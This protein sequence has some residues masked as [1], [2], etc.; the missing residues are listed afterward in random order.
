MGNVRSTARGNDVVVVDDDKTEEEEEDKEEGDV[1]VPTANG[2]ARVQRTPS[3]SPAVVPRRLS[4]RPGCT[5]TLKNIGCKIVCKTSTRE[6]RETR[7]VFPFDEP[8]EEIGAF[9]PSART[10]EGEEQQQQHQNQNT[11]YFQKTILANVTGVISPGIWA[12][13]GPSGAGKSTLL[14]IITRRKTEGILSGSILLDGKPSTTLAIKKYVSYVAQQD[15]FYGGSTVF[16]TILFIAMIK[17]PGVEKLSKEFVYEQVEQVIQAMN[18]EKCRNTYLGNALVRGVSGGEKKR[19]SI[20]AA[21]LSQP[22][23]MFLDEPTSGLDSQ[24]AREVMMLLADLQRR[25]QRTIVTTIHQ[26]STDIFKI[27]DGLILLNRECVYFGPAGRNPIKFFER[28]EGIPKRVSG[29]SVSEYLL[30]VLSFNDSVD[31]VQHYERSELAA[32]NRE[33]VDKTT[34]YEINVN[35]GNDQ[36]DKQFERTLFGELLFLIRYKFF[37]HWLH[38]LYWFSRVIIYALLA[39]TLSVFFYGQDRTMSGIINTN[40]ILFIMIILPMFMAQ[41][42]VDILKTE[43][44][45]YT[46]EIFHYSY[47]RSLS[48]VTAKIFVEIPAS[49]INAILYT[50]IIFYSIG[51]Q[52][53]FWFVVFA[54]FVNMIVCMLIGY[55]IA[56]IVPGEIGPGVVLPVFSTLNMLVSGFFVRFKTI[57]EIWT[58]FYDLSWIQW[59]WSAVMVNEFGDSVEFRDHCTPEGLNDMFVQLN[60]PPNQERAFRFWLRSQS[61]DGTECEPI[62]GFSILNAF[63]LDGR[64]R[65]QSVGY[66]SAWIPVCFLLFYLGVTFIR[67]EKL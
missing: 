10:S 49:A 63:A 13:M 37:V 55:T 40:G 67:H 35:N 64:K 30:E 44:E 17:T 36:E 4:Q 47:Y 62:T 28:L 24:M 7:G 41:G 9:P 42:F 21:L 58:W 16:E 15:I 45:V 50:S 3:I 46:K 14:D 34:T 66:A 59:C 1:V 51:L 2:V 32:K 53:N 57:P 48:Y 19:V 6:R 27:F 39:A 29:Y 11:K 20:A 60:I 38:S 56:A 52:G 26:P 5:I 8:D 22:R 33:E 18:L 31:F 23:C 12:I 65:F 43:R 61:T 54:N 25:E